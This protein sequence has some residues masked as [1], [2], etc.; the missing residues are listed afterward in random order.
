[1]TPVALVPFAR[2]ASCFRRESAPWLTGAGGSFL[3]CVATGSRASATDRWRPGKS[4]RFASLRTCD[5]AQPIAADTEA[6]RRRQYPL[7]GPC[8]ST[9]L[10]DGPAAWRRRV[11]RSFRAGPATMT[12]IRW[13]R[14][15]LPRCGEAGV[16]GPTCG[17]DSAKPSTFST[18]MPAHRDRGSR[19][20]R[21][22]S[23]LGLDDRA[24]AVVISWPSPSA[25]PGASSTRRACCKTA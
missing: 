21:R 20:P 9:P 2:S 6:T 11:A 14:V 22:S 16:D 8:R 25:S 13:P 23:D 3:G 24:L 5:P 18:E 1:M 17:G 19:R 12:P 15:S 10:G 7:V 4:N